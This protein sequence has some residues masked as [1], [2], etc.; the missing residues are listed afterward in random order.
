[1]ARYATTKLIALMFVYRRYMRIEGHRCLHH[2]VDL[3]PSKIPARLSRI[4]AP[5]IKYLRIVN[6]DLPQTSSIRRSARRRVAS[7]VLVKLGVLGRIR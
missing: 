7:C 1:M 4:I 6:G 2:V 3:I 5:A